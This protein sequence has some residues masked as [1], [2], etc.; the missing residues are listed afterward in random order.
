MLPSQEASKIYHDNYMRNSR[1]IGVLWA[2][3]TICFAII[4]VVVFIQPY[5]IGDSVDTPY[6][7]YFGLFHYCI[8]TGLSSRDLIC[9]GTFSD[10]SSIPSGAFKAAAFFVLLSMVLILGC[11]T[12]FALFFFCNTATVYKICA[13]MQLLAA[14]CLVLGC[15]IFPDGWDSEAVRKMCGNKTGKYT[16]G[17][18]SVR[19]AYI[20][21]IIGI[22]DALILSF[23]AFVLGNRQNE[24]L[25]EDLK[26]ENK[27]TSGLSASVTTQNSPPV[28]EAP[29]QPTTSTSTTASASPTAQVVLT[30]TAP[31]SPSSQ[32]LVRSPAHENVEND[33]EELTVPVEDGELDRSV[34]DCTSHKEESP[35]HEN[36]ETDI[37]GQAFKAKVL[38]HQQ[39]I[40]Q[41]V[42]HFHKSVDQRLEEIQGSLF[43]INEVLDARMGAVQT[44][45]V[46]HG[47]SD[48][49]SVLKEGLVDLKEGL[50]TVIREGFS[51]LR[52]AMKTGFNQ[53]DGRLEHMESTLEQTFGHPRSNNGTHASNLSLLVTSSSTITTETYQVDIG[54]ALQMCQEITCHDAQ[55]SAS[56]SSVSIIHAPQIDVSLSSTDIALMGPQSTSSGHSL[57]RCCKVTLEKLPQYKH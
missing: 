52:D 31:I 5:W 3:F 15:M 12:C 57:K 24:L 27:E 34:A 25:Q 11:I 10:F 22:L 53:L 6:A 54:P 43:D 2:I 51:E 48:L 56:A 45:M 40:H 47:V 1:A 4:N 20:L 30:S 44:C 38:V 18:C 7:G 29:A 33:I 46:T 14:V 13:W 23:L 42:K 35:G 41:A 36:V 39:D 37:G 55:T 19:W 9:Q 21:A 32:S 50:Q 8:G 49:V 28:S 17:N 16:L 26:V